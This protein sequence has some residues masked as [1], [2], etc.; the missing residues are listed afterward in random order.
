M[1]DSFLSFDKN[2]VVHM[3]ILGFCTA[4][5][6]GSLEAVVLHISSLLHDL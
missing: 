2:T 3:C 1:C 4:M 5:P 6:A